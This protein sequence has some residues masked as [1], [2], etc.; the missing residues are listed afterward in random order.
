VHFLIKANR[1][2]KATVSSNLATSRRNSAT[3]R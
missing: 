2:R 1:S 3:S